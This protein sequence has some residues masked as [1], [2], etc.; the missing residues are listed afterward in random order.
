MDTVDTPNSQVEI[1]EQ[2]IPGAGFGPVC[3]LGTRLESRKRFMTMTCELV[4]FEAQIATSSEGARARRRT[5]R[6]VRRAFGFLLRKMRRQLRLSDKSVA[7]LV[8]V[9]SDVLWEFRRFLVSKSS[10]QILTDA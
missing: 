4:E 7:L 8:Y 2:P 9:N 6:S 10:V 3:K 1:R 5:A